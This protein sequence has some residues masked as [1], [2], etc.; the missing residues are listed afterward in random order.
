MRTRYVASTLLALASV[1]LASGVR[2]Q[3][4]EQ[5]RGKRFQRY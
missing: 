3:F 2:E 1:G 4:V 5:H